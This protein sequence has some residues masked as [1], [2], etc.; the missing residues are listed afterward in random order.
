MLDSMTGMPAFVRNHRFDVLAANELARALY[1]DLHAEPAWSAN[2]ARFM[3]LDPRAVTFYRDWEGQARR[4]VG[5]IR[6]ETARHPDDGKLTGLVGELVTR[7]HEFRAYWA[8]Q[9]VYVHDFGVKRFRH[10]VVGDLELAYEGMT[11][12]SDPGLTIV[13]YSAEPGTPAEDS[14]QLLG[15]W[16]LSAEGLRAGQ[17]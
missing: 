17:R 15:S 14:L 11:L 6:V 4:A 10:P 16:S 3:F 2:T 1:C 9:D 7:S 13:S 8:A 5:A 12:A